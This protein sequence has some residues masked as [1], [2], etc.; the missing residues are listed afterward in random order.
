MNEAMREKLVI[1]LVNRHLT[2]KMEVHGRIDIPS[3]EVCMD[4][5]LFVE[6][7]EFWGD[8]QDVLEWAT[9]A[10]DEIIEARN[11]RASGGRDLHDEPAD[12]AYMYE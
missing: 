10:R 9:F 4:V 8:K 11:Y 1:E 3:V 12:P 5:L 6:P 2:H 7:L